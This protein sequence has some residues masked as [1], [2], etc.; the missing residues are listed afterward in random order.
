M[1]KLLM[2]W[3]IRE[4]RESEYFEFVVRDYAPSL[5]R[6]GI[7]P[8]EAWYTIYGDGPQILTGAVTEDLQAMQ[9]LL[10]SEEWAELRE[11][12][13]KY[14]TNSADVTLGS[15]TPTKRRQVSTQNERTLTKSKSARRFV[16]RPSHHLASASLGG[17]SRDRLLALRFRCLG[18]RL[19]VLAFIRSAIGPFVIGA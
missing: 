19:L 6:L 9:D 18:C 8:T 13:M 17:V 11:N 14:V 7:Q 1:I 2:S 15:K 3:D 12:L 16:R 4:G 10:S 5:T